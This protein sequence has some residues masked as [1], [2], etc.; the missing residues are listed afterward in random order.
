MKTL[1]LFTLSLLLVSC[2]NTKK[3]V[4]ETKEL[5]YSIVETHIDWKEIFNQQETDYFVYFYST[6][7]AHCRNIKQDILNYYL[8][9]K[10][11]L[12]FVCM[13]K[14]DDRYSNQYE[15]IGVC[16]SNKLYILGTPFL[17]EVNDYKVYQ[18]YA[19]EKAIKEF[20][21]K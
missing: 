6:T 21:S 14:I 13:D 11:D 18:Y 20:L 2:T 10:V 17:I 4:P 3:T 1:F 5:D 19:G 8:S 12:Y 9:E 15:I 16:D 7:C